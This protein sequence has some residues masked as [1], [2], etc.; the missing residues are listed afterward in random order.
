MVLLVVVVEVGD[1][2]LLLWWL[3]VCGVR[4]RCLGDAGI[5]GAA[6]DAVMEWVV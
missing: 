2:R 5:A 3:G 4:G 1:V 6:V